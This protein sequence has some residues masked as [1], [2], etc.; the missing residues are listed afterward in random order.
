MKILSIEK[1]FIITLLFILAQSLYHPL[2]LWNEA[3]F[4]FESFD[5]RGLV[6]GSIF[7]SSYILSLFPFFILIQIKSNKIFLFFLSLI[8]IFLSIDFFIQIIGISH[9][10]SIDEQLLAM[11]ERANY[12]YLF[13]YSPSILQALFLALL[14]TLLLYYI[15]KKT[16][17][18][19]TTIYHLIFSLLSMVF[20]YGVCYKIETFKLST[21]PAPIKI[22]LIVIES[23][24]ITEPVKDRPFNETLET[25]KTKKYKNIIWIIDESVT[26]SYLSLNGYKKNT[27]PYLK[28]LN[29]TSNIIYNFGV[30]NSISNCS[31]QSNLFLRI[32]L[33]PKKFKNFKKQMFELPTIFQYAK[34]AGFKTWLLDSQTKKDSLQNYLTLYDTADIDHFETLDSEV[35]RVDRDKLFLKK[36]SKIVNKKESKTDNFIVLVKYGSHFPYLL[37]YNHAHS[38]F[39][40]VPTVSYGGMNLEHKEELINSYLNSIYSNTDLYL[41]E[42]LSTIDLEKS[43]IFYTSDHGQNI[44]ETPSL[45]RTHCNR[46][47]IVKSEVSVPL[48]VFQKNAKKIFHSQKPL[49]YS[50]IQLFP[51]TLSLFGYSKERVSMYGKTLFKGYSKEEKRQYILSSSLQPKPY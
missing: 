30:V 2:F 10:F 19:K 41:K 34:Q 46:T 13:A 33:N 25:N 37:S 39:N 4:H 47:I 1:L 51:T 22:P 38:P 27:T 26:G 43:I 42:M 12:K 14:L 18:Y 15:R 24:R 45:S 17:L 20:I 6:K 35:K 11:Q 36:L 16:A 29:E 32:G 28:K 7:I 21:Y 40:P 5:L 44:L 31:A 9:G 49:Y 48:M 23:L 3:F 8:F 50:Q